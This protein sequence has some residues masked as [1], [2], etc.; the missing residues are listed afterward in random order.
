MY[1][2]RLQHLRMIKLDNII[3]NNIYLKFRI[4]LIN[5]FYFKLFRFS[6]RLVTISNNFIILI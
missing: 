6:F 3:V 1:F 2:N 5:M 4:K